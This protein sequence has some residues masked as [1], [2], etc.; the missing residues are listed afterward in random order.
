MIRQPP[1]STRTDT[2]F[3]Y[4]TLFRSEV[5]VHGVHL[6]ALVDGG[7]AGPQ[8]L[9][10]D[11]AAVE[12]APRV[13][14]PVGHEHVGTVGFELHHRREVHCRIVAR[15]PPQ[16]QAEHTPTSTPPTPTPQ[17]APL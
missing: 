17:P 6:E 16:P 10:D 7:G 15:P 12:P 1:R 5:G 3:P 8:G 13:A 4:T 9:G 2:L 11:L 14:R